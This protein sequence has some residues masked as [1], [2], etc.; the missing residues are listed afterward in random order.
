MAPKYKQKSREEILD[1]YMDYAVQNGLE[2]S[3]QQLCHDEKIDEV[4]FAEYFETIDQLEKAVWQGLIAASILTVQSDPLFSNYDNRD[5]LLS[6]YYTFFENCA[7]NDQYLLLSLNNGH[8]IRILSVLKELKT[9]YHDFIKEIQPVE[10]LNLG[11]FDNAVG[12]I[13]SSLVAE[14]FYGQL[15]FLLDFWSKDSSESYEKTDVA[16]EKAVKATMDL[17][18]TTP[19]KS[20]LD[21]GKFI[22]Q[23]RMNKS[24]NE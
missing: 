22:W 8:K 19:L 18:D 5:K 7:L 16:I 2:I 4:N 10:V 14:G 12:R 13:S 1:L 17:I 6:F 11:R 15:L 21:F 20:V 23:E 3:I 9:E 24:G